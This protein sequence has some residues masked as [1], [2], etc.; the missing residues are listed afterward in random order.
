MAY[1]VEHYAKL[2]AVEKLAKAT[3]EELDKIK[4][5]EGELNVIDEIKVN[6]EKV[7]PVGKSVDITV[8]KSVSQ[9]TN[10]LKF[11]TEEEVNAKISAVY[12]P[13]GSIPFVSLPE[14]SEDTLGD[15]YNITDKFKTNDKFLEGSGVD[16]PAGTNVAIVS[17]GGEYKYD[18]LSGIVDLTNYPTND[19]ITSKLEEK[20]DVSHTHNYAGSDAPGVSADSAK[21]LDVTTVGSTTKPV[22]FSDGVPVA[23]EYTIE[24]S[25]PSTAVFTDTTYGDA[26]ESEHGLMSVDDKQKL[27][28]IVA[29]TDEEVN[30]MIKTVFG[31]AVEGH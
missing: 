8:P 16:Y 30:K 15:V 5:E 26:T 20:A 23:L 12:E 21:K 27:N 1:D 19:D 18:A 31:G 6:G 3:K 13:K 28:G 17:V 7:N 11:Q 14:P 4:A 22:Y 24:K 2:S 29:A 9:L 25:V 10:D